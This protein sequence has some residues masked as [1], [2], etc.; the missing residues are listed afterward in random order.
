M[1]RV[2]IGLVVELVRHHR[3]RRLSRNR[4]RL[5]QV[6]IRMVGRDRGRRDDHFSAEGPQQLGLLSA[7]L[8]RHRADAAIPLDRCRHREREARVPAGCFDDRAT[9]LEGPVAFRGF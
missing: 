4:A 9:G 3:A 8:V 7:H 2:G 1:M 5:L 6:V